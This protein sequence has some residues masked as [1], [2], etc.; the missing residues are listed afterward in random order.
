M[1]SL[2][3]AIAILVFLFG[4]LWLLRLVRH[5]RLRQVRLEE[6]WDY[7]SFRDALGEEVSSEVALSVHR[8]FE[9]LSPARVPVKPSDR[10][11]R[12]HGITGGD[13]YD[14]LLQ[15][16]SHCRVPQPEEQRACTVETVGD[17]AR[18]MESLR[19]QG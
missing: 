19:I 17:A 4:G 18:L 16:A 6:A 12:L 15:L 2:T 13:V 5:I 7:A 8:F 11:D 9:N 14:E 10:I 3:V 1:S